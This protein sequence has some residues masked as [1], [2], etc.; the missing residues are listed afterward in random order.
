M[1]SISAFANKDAARQSDEAAK[2]WTGENLIGLLSVIPDV[3]AGRAWCTSRSKRPGSGDETLFPLAWHGP[4]A[5]QSAP[6]PLLTVLR[7]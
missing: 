5:L 6:N 4:E 1:A 2:H 7:L 3:I